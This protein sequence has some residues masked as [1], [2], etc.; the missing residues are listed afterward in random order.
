VTKPAVVPRARVDVGTAL[1]V[2]VLALV[3]FAA[4]LPGVVSSHDPN[5]ISAA[6][7]QG[8]SWQHL[9][10]T[11]QTGRDEFSRVIHGA[12]ASLLIGFGAMVVG[13]V[14]GVVIGGLAAT[15]P[16][17]LRH[18]LDRLT[19]LLFSFPGMVLALVLIA[20]LGPSPVTLALA[21]GIGNSPGYARIVRAQVI[22]VAASEYALSQVQLGHSR[23][24]VVA[25][26]IAA[27]VT[28]PLVP[29]ATLG[30]GQAIIWASA[31]SFLGLGAQSPTAEWGLML[32][33]ARSLISQAW[34]L[35]FFP[36]AAIAAVSIT[37][38][39]LG[40]AVQRAL[41]GGTR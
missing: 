19:E 9:F 5:A 18:P 12:R 4:L 13:V 7:L 16:R 27:N 41:L 36:G 20:A 29:L 33:N 34:W 3:I 39:G 17:W 26:T 38:T 32:S 35:T 22:A 25:T 23:R 14:V 11:D 30:V 31:L 40:H 15:G 10:G 1:A 8:P 21:V 6:S 24:Y 2:A 37:L 28:R